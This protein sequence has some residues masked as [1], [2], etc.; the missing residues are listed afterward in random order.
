M[1]RKVIPAMIPKVQPTY[2][3]NTCNILLPPFLKNHLGSVKPA[4]SLRPVL[5]MKV[6]K[7]ILLFI[8][9]LFFWL[10]SN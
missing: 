4:F 8:K 6:S 3:A 5:R 2:C 7:K 1:A 9:Y 10:L